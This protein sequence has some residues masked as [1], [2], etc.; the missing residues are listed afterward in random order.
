MPVQT[1]IDSR[2]NP[3]EGRRNDANKAKNTQDT[4]RASKGDLEQIS[5]DVNTNRV[6]NLESFSRLITKS[7]AKKLKELLQVFTQKYMD[8]G[9]VNYRKFKYELFE[10][11]KFVILI[12][13][14]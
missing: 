7:K 12:R 1:G 14:K 10:Q 6:P 2:T 8:D 13:F 11:T 9:L 4:Q 5:N 3:F